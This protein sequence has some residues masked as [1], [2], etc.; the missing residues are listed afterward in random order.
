MPNPELVHDDDNL[1][2]NTHGGP[3][4][5]FA[6]LRDRWVHTIG[7]AA[8][9]SGELA[10]SLES[11]PDRDPPGCIVSPVYQHLHRH[12]ALDDP[13]VCL[14]L[15]GSFLDHH[16]SAAASLAVE[17]DE[18][19]LEIDVADRCRGA[20]QSLAATYTVALDSSRLVDA[21]PARVVWGGGVLGELTLTLEAVAPCALA[22][23]EAGRRA[24]R[25]QIVAPID[26]SSFTQRL[27]YRWRWARNRGATA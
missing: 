2:V 4:L 9:G 17:G 21:D 24:T 19:V 16:F 8:D 7:L 25:A 5:A 3:R 15:T 10:S 1:I 20:I 12:G 22:L 23:A 11:D 13:G 27:R 6:R 26:P 14:L 18:G